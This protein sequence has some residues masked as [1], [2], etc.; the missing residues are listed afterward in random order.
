MFDRLT[1]GLCASPFSGNTDSLTYSLNQ[2]VQQNYRK[3]IDVAGPY[4]C[5]IQCAEVIDSVIRRYSSLGKEFLSDTDKKN[6]GSFLKG[7]AP[8]VAI[9]IC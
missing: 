8:G 5:T 1:F 6:I 7:F 3:C 9:D 2:T 4:C